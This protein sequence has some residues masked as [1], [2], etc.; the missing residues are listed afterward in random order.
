[1]S[2]NSIE[3]ITKNEYIKDKYS[4]S[5]KA[6]EDKDL[7]NFF[8]IKINYFEELSKFAQEKEIGRASCRERV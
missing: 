7:D 8:R 6:T 3:Y 1:M 4:D 5:P 2:L